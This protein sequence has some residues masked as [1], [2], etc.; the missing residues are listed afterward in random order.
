MR[1]PAR[2]AVG[3]AAV[4]PGAG[5]I[6]PRQCLQAAA[7]ANLG[8]IDS[9]RKGVTTWISELVWREFYRHILVDYPRVCRNRAFKPETERIVWDDD[10][11][12]FRAWAVPRAS[13]ARRSRRDAAEH[14]HDELV[15]VGG[16][17]FE[18]GMA[19]H[20]VGIERDLRVDGGIIGNALQLG[21]YFQAGDD[22][23]KILGQRLT[24][25]KDSNTKFF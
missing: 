25:R 9:G 3:P 17:V 7:E 10:D 8:E 13:A 11:A 23:S 24:G 4:F 5:A 21:G 19:E 16:D 20:R 2:A 1:C 14:F 6:S 12:R 22:S 15:L 18:L